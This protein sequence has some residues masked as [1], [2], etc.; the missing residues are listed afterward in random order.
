MY[1]KHCGKEVADNAVIC[2][3]CGK[4]L[5]KEPDKTV[6]NQIKKADFLFWGSVVIAL[7]VLIALTIAGVAKTIIWSY[8]FCIIISLI[9]VP[10]LNRDIKNV[11]GWFLV[12]LG[13]MIFIMKLLNLG[14]GY[15]FAA[16]IILLGVFIIILSLVKKTNSADKE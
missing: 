10:I 15:I 6:Q 9:G 16:V 5:K 7:G 11:G 3:H 13:I 4:S 1:C 14:L 12:A 2:V 8:V